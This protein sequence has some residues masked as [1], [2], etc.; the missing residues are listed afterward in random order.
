MKIKFCGAAQ[1]VTGSCHLLELEDETK[2]LLDC[3]LYQGHEDEMEQFNNEWSFIPSEIDYLILSHAHI[4]HSGRIPKLIK[5]G[6]KGKIFSTH[7]TFDLCALMLLD[8]AHIQEKDAEYEQK[9]TKRKVRPLYTTEDARASLDYFVGI[10]F[11]KW[12]QIQKGLSFI[13][14]DA[15]HILGS[16]TVSLKIVEK[17]K[18][19]I[20][21]G[22]TGDIGRTNRP[23]LKDPES[24]PLCDYLISESTY[25]GENHMDNIT[26]DELFLK[27]IQETCIDRKGKVI[28]PAFSVGR[29]QEIVFTLDSLI[30]KGRLKNIPVYV[31]S[32]LAINV[33]EVF[34]L[35]PE[36]FDAEMHEYM[37]KEGDPF[38][39]NSLNYVSE[40]EQSKLLNDMDGPAIIISASGMAQSGRVKHHIFHNI[41][42]PNN[43]ILMVGYCANGTLGEKLIKKPSQIKIFGQLLN[44]NARIETLS[45]MSAHAGHDE[46]LAFL[47]NQDKEKLKCI[48]LVHGEPKRQERLKTGLL[49]VGFKKIEIP[50]LE[51][52]FII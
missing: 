21:L 24:M 26:S 13:F 50:T 47:S 40:L 7:A 39:F 17:D 51:Q 19:E 14:N 37:R 44:V 22:F 10:S 45:S 46:I 32:P 42:N 1:T 36:C 20:T 9:K 18:E 48:F 38:G 23:I 11:N 31:D 34:K 12:F 35:H 33:T 52:E 5:D 6:F 49:Q 43:T 3:G 16:A 30:A 25:G 41:E 27:I 15:G 4:D 8:S 2:I 28:I 29:T